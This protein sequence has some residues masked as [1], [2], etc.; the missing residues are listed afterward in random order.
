M[1]SL[2]IFFAL[3]SFFLITTVNGMNNEIKE[4]ITLFDNVQKIPK[5]LQFYA[6]NT[7]IT[8][9]SG[10]CIEKDVEYMKEEAEKSEP[11]FYGAFKKNLNPSR[12]LYYKEMDSKKDKKIKTKKELTECFV[13]LIGPNNKGFFII[14]S[15]IRN[16]SNDNFILLPNSITKKQTITT[17]FPNSDYALSLTE[18][19]KL[20][21]HTL[22]HNTPMTELLNCELPPT[23]FTQLI[24]T[25]DNI[26]LARTEK[27]LYLI[28]FDQNSYKE[29]KITDIASKQNAQQLW[30]NAYKKCNHEPLI[31]FSHIDYT[32]QFP[33]HFFIEISIGNLSSNN[34]IKKNILYHA[35]S[36]QWIELEPLI[37][38]SYTTR[39]F[40]ESI[41]HYARKLH[42]IACERKRKTR[43]IIHTIGRQKMKVMLQTYLIL[44][45]TAIWKKQQEKSAAD[46]HTI[47]Q[48]LKQI[49]Y[50]GCIYTI[51][52]FK[53]IFDEMRHC[54]DK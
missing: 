48:R 5:P 52:G 16:L 33:N 28:S 7:F 17:L 25:E 44:S 4:L 43:N 30:K 54:M 37:N 50:A 29:I 18:E 47:I 6:A 2:K 31:R 46:A 1:M 45:A 53:E 39:W 19:G 38:N 36:S 49:P 9:I 15:E 14:N 8:P 24:V 27:V 42:S 41:F 11:F 21:K 20:Y 12:V 10:A 22:N 35:P 23:T 51:Q 26:C 3:S 32:Q 40:K 34:S 13:N